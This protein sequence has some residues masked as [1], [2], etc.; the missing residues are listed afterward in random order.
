[1]H[2]P[3]LIIRLLGI[4]SVIFCGNELMAFHEIDGRTGDAF[5]A[6]ASAATQTAVA[7]LIGGLVLGL[8]AA[9]FAGQLARILT[10]DAEP[11]MA[12]PSFSDQLLSAPPAKSTKGPAPTS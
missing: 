5:S 11:S 3:T 2:T 12:R 10:F 8:I 7:E 4:G 6:L 1:M 9:L